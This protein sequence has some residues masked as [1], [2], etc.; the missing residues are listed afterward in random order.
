MR[1]EKSAAL[2]MAALFACRSPTT[3]GSTL[4]FLGR[5][6]A[7]TLAGLSWAPDP[8]HSSIVAFDGRLH[9]VKRFTSPRLANPMAVAML[10]IAIRRQ[11][12]TEG[13]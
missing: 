9:V 2:L 7:A 6:P 11:P 5:S 10:G 3:G 4:L 8:N 13:N 12:E 1:L